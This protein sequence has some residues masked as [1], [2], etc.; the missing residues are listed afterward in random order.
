MRF[1]GL[2]PGEGSSYY[3]GSSHSHSLSCDPCFQMVLVFK[4]SQESEFVYQILSV[5]VGN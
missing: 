4:G 3:R 1:K 5:N 2:G